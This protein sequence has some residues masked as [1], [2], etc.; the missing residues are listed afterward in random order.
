MVSLLSIIEKQL[1]TNQNVTI[2]RKEE[3]LNFRQ[4]IALSAPKPL[5]QYSHLV[6]YHIAPTDG[7]Y[8]AGELEVFMKMLVPDLKPNTY[9][10]PYEDENR[11]TIQ[12]RSFVENIGIERITVTEELELL[13]IEMASDGILSGFEDGKRKTENTYELFHQ[14][15]IF[16]KTY[17]DAALAKDML[18]GKVGTNR[19][20]SGTRYQRDISKELLYKS[21]L[22]D[23]H[24]LKPKKKQ[25][26]LARLFS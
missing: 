8:T 25:G 1:K 16:L 2:V 11:L 7:L 12:W 20:D 13:D 18:E 9:L 6:W 26:L 14:R 10:S 24:R 5:K 4:Q 23:N 17:P 15:E 22:P 21:Y 3:E 19:L